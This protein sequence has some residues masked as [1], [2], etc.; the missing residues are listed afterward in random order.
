MP[1]TT[2][3]GFQKV[4]RQ[5]LTA[6]EA[7][8][9]MDFTLDAQYIGGY[10][11]EC[12]FKALVLRLAAEADRPAMLKRLSAGASLHRPEV[13]LGELRNQG[14]EPP[15]D[16]SKRLRRPAWATDLRYETGRRDFGETT[17]FLR[18]ARAVLDWVE[19]QLP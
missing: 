7:L 13:L 2:S 19:G 8:L 4:A 15:F 18:T 10:M 17:A 5:R 1:P 14:V 12:A 11:V 16:L 3:H 9:S 6:A